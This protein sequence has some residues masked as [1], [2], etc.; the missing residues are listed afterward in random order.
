VPQEECSIDQ[1]AAK[2]QARYIDDVFPL[3][4]LRDRRCDHQDHEDKGFQGPRF[5]HGQDTR[6]CWGTDFGADRL[7]YSL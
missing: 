6:Q 3:P 5:P 7:G 1:V 4:E 2:H